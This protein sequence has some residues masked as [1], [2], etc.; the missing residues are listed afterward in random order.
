MKTF[1]SFLLKLGVTL[2]IFVLIFLEFGGGF[3]EV[4]TAALDG[5]EGFEVANPAYPGTA[6]RLRARLSGTP[7]PPPRLPVALDKVCIAAAE[8]AVFVRTA[9]GDYRRFKPARHCGEGGLTAVWE[10]DASGSFRA[11]PLA[12][13]P[14]RSYFRLPGF[15]LGPADLPDP[16]AHA[17]G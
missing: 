16:L 17:R 12:D 3:V 9:A 5:P 14:A 6:G 1:L 4:D 2:A 13:A 11:V 10:P 8:N 15:Q 7:L